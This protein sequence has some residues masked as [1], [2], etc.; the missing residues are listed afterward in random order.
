MTTTD[1][2]AEGTPEPGLVPAAT[3][4]ALAIGAFSNLT[5]PQLRP[6][7]E[8][9]DEVGF[10]GD[11]ALIAYMAS[12]ATVE[13][14]EKRQVA[15][16][17][18]RTT[19]RPVHVDRFLGIYR[20][21]LASW[22]RYDVVIATDTRDVYFQGDPS[23][24]IRTRLPRERRL[25]VAG[26][27]SIQYRDEPWGRENL[28]QAYGPVILDVM[29]DD[30]VINVGALG[31]EPELM[32]DLC[33]NIFLT[34][35]GGRIPIADQAAFNVLLRTRPYRDV[36]WLARQRDG[37]ACHAGTTADPGKLG[38]FRPFLT[39]SEPSFGK[40]V[41]L[42]SAGEPFCIVHQYDRVPEWNRLVREKHGGPAKEP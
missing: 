26:S 4:R 36:V 19:Q 6:W 39:E 2:P 24:W 8:S 13:E 40:G 32:K 34:S 22:R 17:R 29:K 37:W 18:E 30:E 15:V 1:S 20:Y 21:L 5:W 31:G 14:L 16:V 42:T 7:V 12:D 9:L 41:V 33:L 27:E 23:A 28:E 11:R 38:S 35:C 25:L 10:A 3:G